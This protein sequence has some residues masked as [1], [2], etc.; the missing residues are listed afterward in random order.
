MELEGKICVDVDD[1]SCLF[2]GKELFWSWRVWSL[3]LAKISVSDNKVTSRA[4]SG[5]INPSISV[6]AAPTLPVRGKAAGSCLDKKSEKLSRSLVISCE[7]DI[8][9][10]KV[11]H[12]QSNAFTRCNEVAVSCFQAVRQLEA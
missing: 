1:S 12:R 5:I 7:H 2:R 10:E 8:S 6:A 3:S 9:E 4:L 11:D